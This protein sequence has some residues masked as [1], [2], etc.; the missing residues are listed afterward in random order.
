M[1]QNIVLKK[2]KINKTHIPCFSHG[3]FVV[4]NDKAEG[5]LTFTALSPV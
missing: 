3:N 1:R 5:F 4:S 2:L